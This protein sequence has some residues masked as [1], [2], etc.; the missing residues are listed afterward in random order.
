MGGIALW[1]KN[2]LSTLTENGYEAVV[3]TPMT[4]LNRTKGARSAK[5]V[6]YISGHDWQKLHWL[7]RLLGLFKY[8][9]TRKEP[10]ARGRHLGRL[11]SHPP[12]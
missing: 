10:G 12:P 6:R 9:V 1:A 4:R 5:Q 8:M 7:Y 3:M 11:A 2:L